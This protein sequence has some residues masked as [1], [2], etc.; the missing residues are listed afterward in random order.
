VNCTQLYTGHSIP[1]VPK[2]N[3]ITLVYSS[4]SVQQESV[5]KKYNVNVEVLKQTNKQTNKQTKM[6]CL[7]WQLNFY[8]FWQIY[9]WNSK[10]LIT[11][12]LYWLKSVV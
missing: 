12:E 8:T 3:F 2:M 10:R 11:Q 7:K 1:P 5:L 6:L 9:I 4:C